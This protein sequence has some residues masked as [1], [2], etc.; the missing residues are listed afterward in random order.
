MNRYQRRY[1]RRSPVNTAKIASLVTASLFLGLVVLV[2]TINTY[3]R[4]ADQ[5]RLDREYSTNK[6][7][8]DK[9]MEQRHTKPSFDTQS[10]SQ[11]QEELLEKQ[12]ALIKESQRKYGTDPLYLKPHER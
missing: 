9:S 11:Y 6:D 12:T 8:F 7:A 10:I 1:K 2:A 5:H 4:S 3:T